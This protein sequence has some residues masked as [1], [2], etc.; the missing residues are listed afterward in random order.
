[1]DAKCKQNFGTVEK[2]RV[3]DRIVGVLKQGMP[4]GK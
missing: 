2:T 1:V 3:V 4:L